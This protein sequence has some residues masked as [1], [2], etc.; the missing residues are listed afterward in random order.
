LSKRLD[1]P[2][3]ESIADL[4][5]QLVDEG[6]KVVKAEVNLYKEIA[7][8]RAAKARNGLIALVAGGILAFDAL[9]VLLIMLAQ[10]LAVQIGPV[11]SG[12]IVATLLAIP[13]YLLV[14]FGSDRLGALG[15]DEEEQAALRAAEQ[16]P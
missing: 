2:A 6:G 11:V 13:A 14:R 5:H 12:L 9:I 10:G 3:D 7:R 4:F 1:D 8:H 15:G 16:R